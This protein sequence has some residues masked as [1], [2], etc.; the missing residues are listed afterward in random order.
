MTIYTKY[1]RMF[2]TKSSAS[3]T[4]SSAASCSTGSSYCRN[5]LASSS[6]IELL[7]LSSEEMRPSLA[8][9]NDKLH[10]GMQLILLK[11]ACI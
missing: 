3:I 4:S 9:Q 8:E 1:I 2:H 5:F 10:Q 7:A 11:T 6:V